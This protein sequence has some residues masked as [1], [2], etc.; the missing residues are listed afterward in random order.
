[1]IALELPLSHLDF[2]LDLHHGPF[3]LAVGIGEASVRE[4]LAA[5][6]T[7]ARETKARGNKR[8]LLDL[9]SVHFKASDAEHRQVGI[10]TAQ[11]L[12]H[13][14]RVA[15]VVNGDYWVGLG[16]AAARDSGLDLRTFTDIVKATNWIA[17]LD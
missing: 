1:M 7:V 2:T 12:G 9:L 13:L 17:E 5:L 14:K 3:L 16:E 8:A 4:G 15:V 10:Y 6:D 11:V